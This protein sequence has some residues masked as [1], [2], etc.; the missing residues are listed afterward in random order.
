MV[1]RRV[2]PDGGVKAKPYGRPAAGLDPAVVV[3]GVAN[4]KAELG[5]GADDVAVEC[6]RQSPHL[7]VALAHDH[8]ARP[9][10]L[11]QA[12]DER[13]RRGRPNALELRAARA[14]PVALDLPARAKQ[15][16]T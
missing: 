13:A 4:S 15:D 2:W 14:A 11:P 8:E 9:C 16:G 6:G 12:D 5:V 10:P 3:G 7:I 1:V